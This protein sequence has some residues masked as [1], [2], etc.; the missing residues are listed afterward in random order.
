[1]FNKHCIK[2]I[3]VSPQR[4]IKFLEELCHPHS[5]RR[6][7]CV[8]IMVSSYRVWGKLSKTKLILRWNIANTVPLC[9]VGHERAALQQLHFSPGGYEKHF[10][11]Q[12]WIGWIN[13]TARNHLLNPQYLL[14]V[15][16]GT[17]ILHTSFLFVLHLNN[18]T[19]DL[20]RSV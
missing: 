12:Y 5:F 18:L 19:L 8:S 4:L 17:T 13:R 1:M 20:P 11:I 10:W 16:V 15:L 7:Y 3:S 9:L 2:E 14:H 6:S